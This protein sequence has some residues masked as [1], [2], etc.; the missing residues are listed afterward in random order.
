[1]IK[2]LIESDDY[3]LRNR[4]KSCSYNLNRHELS[5]ILIENMLHYNGVGLSA[6]QIGIEERAFCMMIDVETEETIT[7]FNPRII[8]SYSKEVVLEEGCLSY[9]GVFLD[10]KR[11]DSVVVKYEDANGNLHKEKLTGF[12]S[13]VFQ[14]EYD[15][16]EGIN[17]IQRKI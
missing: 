4:I 8:K 10:A 14:H 13:R 12:T 11:P 15:N 17:F 6:N 7:C 9:P 3:M 16:M 2:K 1:M 5:K